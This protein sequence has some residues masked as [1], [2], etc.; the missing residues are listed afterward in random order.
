MGEKDFNI[1]FVK[2]NG[3]FIAMKGPSF[4]TELENSMDII[5]K[6]GCKINKIEQILLSENYGI[7][8]L[9]FIQK[10][11]NTLKIYPR[12]FSQIKN[13]KEIFI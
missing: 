7:R 10:N 2:I 13:N 5:Q 6:L 4:E 9:I 3:I 8:Y 11:K 12:S 1:P